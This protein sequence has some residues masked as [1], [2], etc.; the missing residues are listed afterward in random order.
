MNEK[1]K[2]NKKAL[3]VVE[4]IARNEVEKVRCGWPPV[5]SGILHQPKR[6]KQKED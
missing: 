4:R 3:K 2:I 5:C 6:P 1:E